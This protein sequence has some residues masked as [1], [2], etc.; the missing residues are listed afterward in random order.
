MQRVGGEG[1]GW[2]EVALPP[3]DGRL[4][5][6]LRPDPWQRPAVLNGLCPPPHGPM[7]WGVSGAQ[8]GNKQFV[9]FCSQQNRQAKPPTWGWL[10]VDLAPPRFDGDRKPKTH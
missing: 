8:H 4:R 3:L 5:R 2:Q 9:A 6:S 10:T 7:G 1:V